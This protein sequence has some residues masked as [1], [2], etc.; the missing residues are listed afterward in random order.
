MAWTIGFFI[1]SS[2]ILHV[3]GIL[4]LALGLWRRDPTVMILASLFIC[5]WVVHSMVYLDYHYIY[6]KLPFMLW[7][8]GYLMSEFLKIRGSSKKAMTWISTAFA[9][10]S[11]L[12]TALL[13]F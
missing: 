7:F 2:A 11:L 10:S 9:L 6:V 3:C 5:L 1:V 12:G 13:V 8:T 4:G